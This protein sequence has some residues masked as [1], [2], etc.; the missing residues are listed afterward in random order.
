MRTFSIGGTISTIA[1]TGVDAGSTNYNTAAAANTLPMFVNGGQGGN[2][3]D[4]AVDP[5]TGDV[6]YPGGHLIYKLSASTGKWVVVA[7]GGSTIYTSGDGSASVYSPWQYRVLGWDGTNV[8]AGTTS[9]NSGNNSNTNAMLK[10]YNSATGIQTGVA[11]LATG[12][13]SNNT[14]FTSGT[15][16]ASSCAVPDTEQSYNRR[17]SYDSY[18]S[19]PRWIVSS[20]NATSVKAIDMSISSYSN[21]GNAYSLTGLSVGLVSFAYRHDATHNIVYYCGTDGVLHKH[22]ITA[23]TDTAYSWPVT[24]VQCTGRA[25]VYDSARNSLI[26]PYF[27]NGLYGVA[28]YTQ[29]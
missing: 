29:P 19:P 15:I 22:D 27:Q 23:S 7:G 3:D 20:S 16:A 12:T 13:A 8:L 28:E 4:L 5:T 11:G 10:L 21:T 26:F 17:A 6:Y 9:R 14:Y 1:G 18:A 2:Y 25:L 24:S